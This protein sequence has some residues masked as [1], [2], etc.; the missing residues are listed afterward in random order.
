[1]KKGI[2]LTIIVLFVSLGLTAQDLHSSHR[3]SV[4]QSI[5]YNDDAS[6][7]SYQDIEDAISGT[8]SVWTKIF[9]HKSKNLLEPYVWVDA[10]ST[11]GTAASTTFKLYSKIGPYEPWILRESATWVNGSDTAF[12]MASD[13]THALEY[14]KFEIKSSSSG[15]SVDIREFQLKSIKR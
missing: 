1:M 11:G 13:S 6:Y 9:R 3:V 15:F 14:Y 10:D 4:D 7:F 2:L 5:D 12:I 8:D